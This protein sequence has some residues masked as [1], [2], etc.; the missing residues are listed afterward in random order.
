MKKISSILIGFIL[1]FNLHLKADE[2]MW[3]LPLIEKLN[4]EKMQ[5]MGLE[6]TADQIY[7]INNSSLKDAIVRFGGGCTGE[8]ISDKGLLLTNHHCGYGVIQRHSSV[9]NDYLT[10]GFWAG[11]FK[12]EIPSPGLSVTFLLSIEDVTEKIN[13]QLEDNMTEADRLNKIRT[14]TREIESAVTTEKFQIARVHT[15]YG[16]NQFYLIVYE[17]FPDVRFVGAPPSSIGKFGADTDNWMWPRQTGDFAIF[18]VYSGPDGKPAEYSPENIPLKPKH[19]L[20]VSNKGVKEGD[21]AMVLGYPGSTS[22]YMTSAE[23]KQV[24]DITNSNRIKIRGVRQ[25]IMLADMLASDK[26]RIQYASKYSGSTNYWKYSIGQ[27]RGLQRLN[28]MDKKKAQEN[29]FI[30]WVNAD[31]SRKDKYGQALNL[32]ENA[33]KGRAEFLNANQYIMESLRN[34]EIYQMAGRAASLQNLLSEKTPDQTKV[35]E[36][37][38][39]L[40]TA[41]AAFYKNYNAPT[42]QKVIAAMAELFYN[43]VDKAFHPDFVAEAH[44]KFKG[45]FKK[46]SADL[47]S[48]SVFVS[49][50]ALN[51]FLNKPSAKVLAKD[52]A[53]IGSLSIN[54]KIREL[55]EKVAGYN[56]DLQK[57]QRL[58]ISGLMEMHPDKVFYPDA[59]STMRLTY[60]TVA[61]YNPQDAVRYNYVTTMKGI[62]EKEDPDNWE[63]VVPEKLK[64][65]YNKK[66]FGPYGTNGE[67]IVNFISTNDIT[68]GNSGSPVINGKGELIGLAFDGNWE[69]MSGDI[70]F[71]N[72]IQR[73]IS[74]DARYI[75][76]IIDKYA[77]ARNLIEEMTI[78]N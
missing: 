12:E 62:I 56:L 64:E 61:S 50:A 73:T 65:L 28:V 51:N 9:E 31:Q 43:D 22:R 4:I 58:Y 23:V 21:Y 55:S 37:I 7:S 76:F 45:D 75:L 1:L 60:G 72:E 68:G 16:G 24:M 59:N 20:P 13:S 34:G 35:N 41:A 39:Q 40:K 70:A 5:S 33:V 18:R 42:D 47:F 27:N 78:I 46:Y 48:K 25:E 30:N 74:V 11:S 38:E 26:V 10:N 69:A 3:L 32:I 36:A 54:S 66:D 53:V 17:N 77:G 44:K 15:Y 49:E 19:Y 63:F 57:G 2:G 67:M 29:D 52:P 14:I 6:L 8:I 71:E